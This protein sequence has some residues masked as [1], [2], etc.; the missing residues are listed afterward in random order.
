MCCRFNFFDKTLIVL[1]AR[2]GGVS[3]ISFAS[4]IDAL[5]GIASANFSLIFFDHRNNTKISE[6][7]SLALMKKRIAED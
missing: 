3:F 7:W 6:N 5:G 4:I 2:S 1:S